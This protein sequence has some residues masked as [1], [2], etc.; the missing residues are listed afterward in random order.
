MKRIGIFVLSA[1][2]AAVLALPGC[3]SVYYNAM[4]KIGFEKRDILVNRV[5][6]A[7]DAQEV[8][9][10][11]FRS[12]LEK[13]GSVVNYQGGKLQD[14][15]DEL[16]AELNRSEAKAE[17][18]SKRISDVEAVAGALFDEWEQELEQFS[19]DRLRQ[20]SKRKLADTKQSYRK[21]IGAMKKA[22]AS[23]DPVLSA[24]RDQVLFLKHNLNAKAVAS[25]QEEVKSVRSDISLLIKEMERSIKE[26]E[27]FMSSLSERTM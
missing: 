9:K 27:T 24:F 1:L 12:A 23:I 19:N 21:M 4:E 22:E 2:I 26:A 17:A 25:I 18:V 5:E 20:A 8:A 10:E 13:F 15:Y 6:D 16:S 3:Q 14:I 11:Q 7:R